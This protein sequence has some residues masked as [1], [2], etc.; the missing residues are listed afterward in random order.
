MGAAERL[1]EIYTFEDLQLMCG[2]GKK[3]SRAKVEA[4]AKDQ[5]I[6]Y[7]YDG[8]G[9][10]WTTLEALNAAL[11]LRPLQNDDVPK[12]EDLI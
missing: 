12:M 2:G 8:K 7:R 3:V 9:G 5:G 6:K 1:P 11:G 4:W 10:I